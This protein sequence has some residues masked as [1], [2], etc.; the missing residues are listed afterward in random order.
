MTLQELQKQVLELPTGD[1]WALFKVLV[2][3]FQ[4]DRLEPLQIHEPSQTKRSDG[5]LGWSAG[6][7]ERTAGAWQG[8]PLKRGEQGEYDQRDWSSFE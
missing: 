3:S 4:P 1:R 5:K 6:F 8:E 7:F 2:E